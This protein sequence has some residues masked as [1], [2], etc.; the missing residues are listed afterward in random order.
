MS[1]ATA[2]L[3]LDGTLIESRT[4]ERRDVSNP[5]LL[6]TRA[7]VPLVPQEEG[8]AAVASTKRAFTSWRSTSVGVRAHIFLKCQ[9][10]L[11]ERALLTAEQDQTLADA[12]PGEPVR[13]PWPRRPGRSPQV[14]SHDPVTPPPP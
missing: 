6:A 4:P 1:V 5:A 14:P 12:V 7:R 11:P 2:K 10:S 8:A 9:Q 13:R 3:L